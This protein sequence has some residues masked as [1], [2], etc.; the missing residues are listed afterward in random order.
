MVRQQV[1]YIRFDTVGSAAR[2][3]VPVSSAKKA[4]LPKPRKQKRKVVYVDP[5]AILGILVAVFMLI[6]MTAG[7]VEFLAV[8][9]EAAQM[10]QYVSQL[11][12]RNEELNREYESGYDLEAVERTALALGMVPKDQVETIT[13]HVELSQEMETVTLWEWIGTF[14]TGLFA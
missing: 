10:E 13:I 1:Q 4:V 6:M 2:K 5:V 12:S 14:L 11:S 7:I 9:Q 3:P 8:R